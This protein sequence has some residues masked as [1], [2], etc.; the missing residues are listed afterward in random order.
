MVITNLP[1]PDPL[2]RKMSQVVTA[3][4]KAFTNIVNTNVKTM[5]DVA[6]YAIRDALN[7]TVLGVMEGVEQEIDLF[8]RSMAKAATRPGE[9]KK[10]H[11]TAGRLAQSATV[12]EYQRFHVGR[13][14]RGRRSSFASSENFTR[15]A[16][17]KLLSA[18]SSPAFYTATEQGVEF[19]NKAHLDQTAAQWYRL[20]F[21]A[22]L[23]GKTSRKHGI[24]NI[25]FYGE[26]VS[27]LSLRGFGPSA[28][29]SMPAGIWDPSGK[30]DPS[31]RGEDEFVPSSLFEASYAGQNLVGVALG[32]GASS[33]FYA[34]RATLG[35]KGTAFLDA[36]IRVLAE[37]LGV[38]WT[39]LMDSWFQEAANESKGPISKFITPDEAKVGIKALKKASTVTQKAKAEFQTEFNRIAG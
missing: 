25:K 30:P 16:G 32:G 15:Y 12:S 23:R 19:A 22:G 5:G 29:F 17:G 21:G 20:N 9:K 10:I 1:G 34:G 27:P 39:V 35:I 37:Q 31:R 7:Q 28:P 33:R 18:L 24:H 8:L 13:N 11:E 3:T 2:A 38:G 14:R 36:G 4:D 6:E 26:A